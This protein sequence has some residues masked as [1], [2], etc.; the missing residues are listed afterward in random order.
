MVEEEIQRSTPDPGWKHYHEPRPRSSTQFYLEH[1]NKIMTWHHQSLH[2]VSSYIIININIQFCISLVHF[3]AEEGQ[4]MSETFCIYRPLNYVSVC[5]SLVHFA[6]EEGRA[7]V[8]NVLYHT[9]HRLTTLVFI[10]QRSYEP[11]YHKN[12]SV[13]C[14]TSLTECCW[15]FQLWAVQHCSLSRQSLSWWWVHWRALHHPT[16]VCE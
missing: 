15:V 4:R 5:I 13:H 8:R 10:H 2:H 11:L 9:D 6:A 12:V 1:T 3:A 16:A 14:I 7:T